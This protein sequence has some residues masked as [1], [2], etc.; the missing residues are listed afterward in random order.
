MM[1]SKSS[2]LCLASIELTSLGFISCLVSG[3]AAQLVVMPLPI[4]FL[5]LVADTGPERL[6]PQDGLPGGRPD[7]RYI[8]S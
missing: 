6:W 7:I 2:M 1:V 3:L 8:L 5:A 4:S